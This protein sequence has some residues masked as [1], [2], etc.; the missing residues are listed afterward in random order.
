MKPVTYCSTL[1][2]RLDRQDGAI[3]ALGWSPDGA[4]IAWQ[5]SRRR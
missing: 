5:A 3:T 4:R 2:R 1:V